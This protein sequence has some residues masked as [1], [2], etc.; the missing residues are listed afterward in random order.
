MSKSNAPR[1]LIYDCE[2]SLQPVAV[3][4]LAN[5]DWIDP[6]NILGERHLVS[7]CWK[8]LGESKVHSVSLLNDPKRFAKNP[9]DDAHICKVFHDVLMQAD[10]LVAH[11]GDR[12]DLPYIKTRML[13]HGMSPLP[14]ITS[15]D[16]YKVAKQQFLCN[17]NKLDYLGRLLGFGGKKNTPSGLWLDVL[18]GSRKAIHT[19]VEYNKRDVTLLEK[20]FKRLVPYIS[21]SVNRELY[22]GTGCPY[23]GS[24][25]IQSRG[26]H[27]A[28]SRTYQRFQ[29]QS[30]QGWFKEAKPL[31]KNTT[32]YRIL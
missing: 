16:T 21:N 10:C 28:I 4:Q 9:H 29:C 6:K 15:V 1:V 22:G 8:W 31:G 17:S 11:N 3:F 13:V 23:C 27:K 2:T 12:F 19:M 26:T 24:H 14:P 25:K 18:S 5:N 30:C 32:K 7:I 20:V